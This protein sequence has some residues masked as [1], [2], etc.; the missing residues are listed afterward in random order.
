MAICLVRGTGDVGSAVAHALYR[1]GHRVVLHDGAAPA[2]PRRGM[3]F[4]DALFDGCAQ[5]EGVLAKRARDLA[6]LPDMVRCGRAVPVSK[7]DFSAV[8]E[9]LVPDVL[10]DARMRKRDRPEL[11]IRLARLTIGLGPNFIAGENT[12]LAIET[13]WGD[14]LGRLI[15]SG[16]ARP[17]A[18][19]PQAIDGIARQRYVYAPAAGVLRTDYRIGDHVEAN[20]PIARIGETPLTAPISGCIRGLTHDGVYVETRT[21]IIEIDPRDDPALV[22]GLGKRPSAIAASVLAAVNT[23]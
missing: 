1:G 18:G 6:D 4:V 21:K 11:Q 10:V 14:D 15:R 2:H 3:A 17:L 12:D 23:M 20:A 16:A 22:F 13:G 8:L 9:R 19:E 7:D 5:L